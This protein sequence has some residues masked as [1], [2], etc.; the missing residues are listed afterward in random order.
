MESLT[1]NPNPSDDESNAIPRNRLFVLVDGTF[2]VRWSEGRVQELESGQYRAYD[3]KSFGASITDYELHQLQNAGLVKQYDKERV[4]LCPLPERGDTGKLLTPWEVNR[5]RS[6]Y[7]NTTLP[8][9]SLDDVNTTLDDLGLANA[10]EAR[11]RDNFVVL[12]GENGISFPKF[13]DAEKA[14]VLL[15]GKAPDAFANTV[16]AFVETTRKH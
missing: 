13:D 6:Y 10:F 1:T 4:V 8:A 7:L 14:R 3:K 5:T 15:A 2:V 16:I 9:T 12:W 11:V